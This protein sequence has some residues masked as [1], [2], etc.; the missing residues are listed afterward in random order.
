IVGTPLGAEDEE[1]A[2]PHPH[3]DRPGVAAR[4]VLRLPRQRQPL[5]HAARAVLLQVRHTHLL[6]WLLFATAVLWSKRCCLSYGA[7]LRAEWD[8]RPAGEAG[9]SPG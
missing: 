4:R 7:V 1:A 5:R 2:Q 6:S 3:V 9:R 8:R